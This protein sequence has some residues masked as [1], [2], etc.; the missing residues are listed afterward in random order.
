MASAAP[1]IDARHLADQ[2]TFRA[3]MDAMAH[4]GLVKPLDALPSDAPR[5]FTAAAAALALCLVD[6]ETPVWLDAPARAHEAPAWLR[7]HTGVRI[8]DDPKEAAFA[9]I[10]D[11]RATPDFAAFAQGSLDYPDRS[12]TLILQIEHFGAAEALTLAGPGIAGTRAFSA[13]PLP[14]DFAARLTANHDCAPLGVDLI[15]V[16]SSAIAALP[17]STRLV[18]GRA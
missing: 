14:D 17:R 4:P 9:F 2:A 16:S 5:P 11:A 12:A 1:C 7:F 10:S 3:V 15:L 18:L 13:T 6:F 8:T